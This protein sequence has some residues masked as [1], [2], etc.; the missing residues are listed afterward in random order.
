MINKVIQI[1]RE[2]N[3]TIAVS[4]SLTGGMIC[5]RLVDVPG[6]SDVFKEGFVTY[7]NKAKRHTLGVDKSTLK[8]YGA[9]SKKTAKE[10]A[11]G[12][13]YVA[14]SDVAISTTGIAG[15]DGGSDEKPVGLVYIGCYFKGK[16]VVEKHVFEGDRNAVREAT[17]EAAFE[18]VYKV[19]K[20]KIK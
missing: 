12:T 16:V 19:L 14:D 6:V 20:N 11:I 18:L 1:L 4:E 15:P 2:N 13:A 8:K 7:S 9:V 3:L 5:S 17:T 10:M